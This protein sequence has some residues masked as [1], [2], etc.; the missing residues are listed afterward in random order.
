MEG[1]GGKGEGA[2]GTSAKCDN[3]VVFLRNSEL[4]TERSGCRAG[5]QSRPKA[6]ACCSS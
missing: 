6:S 1:E 4:N 5:A 2:A 3:R